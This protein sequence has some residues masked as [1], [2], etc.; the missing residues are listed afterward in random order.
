MWR[1]AKRAQLLRTSR[2]RSPSRR[3][4]NDRIAEGRGIEPESIVGSRIYEPNR[5]SLIRRV[6]VLKEEAALQLRV[7]LVLNSDGE[8]ALVSDDGGELPAIGNLSGKPLLLRNGEFPH[9]T[10]HKAVL[11]AQ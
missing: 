7:I 10:E 1:I 8:S 4:A 5:A 6:G 2:R 11:G 9:R 3:E